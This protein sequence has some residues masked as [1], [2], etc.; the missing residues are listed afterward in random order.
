[1]DE[2]PVCFDE[3]AFMAV[4]DHDEEL[5]RE[6]LGCYLE[7]S[8]RVL[9]EL[10]I[11]LAEGSMERARYLIHT[12]KGSS[13]NVYANRMREAATRLEIAIRAASTAE[14]GPGLARLRQCRQELVAHLRV[15]RPEIA[16]AG[17]MLR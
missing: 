8:G 4:L 3:D 17:C 11:A 10:Q 6:I 2:S 7:D 13:A 12:L 9:D 1:M 15:V 14:L 16:T 5:L